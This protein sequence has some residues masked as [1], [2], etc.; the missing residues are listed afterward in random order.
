VK[1]RQL[2]PFI[3]GCANKLPLS[4]KSNSVSGIAFLGLGGKM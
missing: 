4:Q 3:F 1:I 2:E